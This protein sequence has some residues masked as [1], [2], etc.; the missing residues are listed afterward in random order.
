M[1]PG[2]PEKQQEL[3]AT[4]PSLHPPNVSFSFLNLIGKLRLAVILV[5]SPSTHWFHS[6]KRKAYLLLKLSSG[7]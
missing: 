2:P 1:N 5:L 3:L 6:V 4:A 7:N